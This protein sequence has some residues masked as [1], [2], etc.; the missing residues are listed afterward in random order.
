M[1]TK[2]QKWG[3]SL[4]LRIPSGFAKSMHIANGAAVDVSLKNNKLIIAPSVEKKML[5]EEM[6][7]KVTP[8]NIHAEIKSGHAVGKEL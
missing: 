5:L 8:K 4:A 2:I 7:E 3:N 6:L 1:N